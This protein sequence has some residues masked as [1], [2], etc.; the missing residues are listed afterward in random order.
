MMVNSS[1]VAWFDFCPL[2]SEPFFVLYDTLQQ[3]ILQVCL[4]YFEVYEKVLLLFVLILLVWYWVDP[5]SFAT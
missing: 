3:Y 2:F 1:Q 5:I 4:V